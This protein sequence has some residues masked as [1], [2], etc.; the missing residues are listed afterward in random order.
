[1]PV[2]AAQPLDPERFVDAGPDRSTQP[3]PSIPA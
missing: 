3:A 2:I 1:V